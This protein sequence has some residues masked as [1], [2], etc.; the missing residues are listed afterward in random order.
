MTHETFRIAGVVTWAALAAS[1]AWAGGQGPSRDYF[2]TCG[3]T[4]ILKVRGGTA[5]SAPGRF[6]NEFPIAVTGTVHTAGFV[7][8]GMGSEYDFN[9]DALDRDF[10][11]DAPDGAQIYDGT[12]DG[13]F[14]YAIDYATGGV[15]RFKK[16]WKQAELMWT[17]GGEPGAYLGI[18]WDPS[19]D[20]FWVSRYRGGRAVENYSRAGNLLSDFNVGNNKITCLALDHRTGTLWMGDADDV[21]AF[22]GWDR[23]GQLVDSID[24]GFDEPTVGGEFDLG[25]V[26]KIRSFDVTRGEHIEGGEGTLKTVD[27]ERM[28]IDSESLQNDSERMD[29]VVRLKSNVVAPDRLDIM[30]ECKIDEPGGQSQLF[31]RNWNTGDFDLVDDRAISTPIKYQSALNLDALNYVRDDG[32]IEVRIRHDVPMP[33]G[34]TVRSQSDLVQVVVRGS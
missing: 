4:I 2:L 11:L 25:A 30:V 8:G 27:G 33:Q 17:L 13:Q 15:Y 19:N 10:T 29:L 20:T 21:A 16:N 22:R 31:A 32:I 18:T 24:Y 6:A 26:A 9:L 14:F 1:S 7:N 5:D 34:G 12:T 23:T 3:D 28:K